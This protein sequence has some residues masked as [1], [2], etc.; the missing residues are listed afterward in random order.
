VIE[1]IHGEDIVESSAREVETDCV[2]GDIA[3]GL[4]IVPFE[5]LFFHPGEPAAF[6]FDVS[7]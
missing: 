4:S 3:F 5:A 7:A 2:F 1:P 6:H